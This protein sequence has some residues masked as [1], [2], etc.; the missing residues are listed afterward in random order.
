M[1]P[2]SL[3]DVLSC[4][5][6]P[7]DAQSVLR[8]LFGFSDG[9]PP[10]IGVVSVHDQIRA[11]RGKHI[12]LD[13]IL[14]VP[15]D[16]ADNDL[17]DIA[18]GIQGARGILGQVGIGI[19]RVRYHTVTRGEADGADVIESKEEAKRLTRR[20]RGSSD[21]A[22][23]VFFVPEYNVTVLGDIKAGICAIPTCNKN[24]YAFNGCVIG[25]RNQSG[26]VDGPRMPRLLA[27]E[28]G[29]AMG[30]IHRDISGNLMEQGGVG[31]DLTDRQGRRM[32]RDC[33]MQ[34]GCDI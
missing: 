27:H 16:F 24:V 17:R 3:R 15:E 26:P 6:A 29:H 2:V 32:R 4:I 28:L 14:V 11:L 33:F 31:T 18:F 12:H 21:D 22:M 1:E 8:H 34:D 23:D 30:R 20:F 13:V 5:D 10:G 19:G 7:A 25:M 9:R